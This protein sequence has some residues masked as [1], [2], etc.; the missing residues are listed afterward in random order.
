MTDHAL[1]RRDSGSA[2][3]LAMVNYGLLFASIFFAG[4]PALIAAIIAYSQRDDAPSPART[5]L[6]FQIRIFW[7]AF[8]LSLGAGAC[9]LGAVISAAG[10]LVAFG[11]A[12]GWRGFDDFDI[13]LSRLSIDG[14]VI[15]LIVGFAVFS[16]LSA[17]WLVAAPAIGF[18]RLASQRGIGHSARP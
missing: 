7:V 1:P 2:Y 5:H 15:A 4:V 3:N 11:Q 10:D 12:N 9:A 13:D 6:N 18:I 8:V 17:A 14:T 16:V